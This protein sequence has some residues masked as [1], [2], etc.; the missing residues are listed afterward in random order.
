MN[1]IE[2]FTLSKLSSESISSQALCNFRVH[3]PYKVSELLN[4]ILLPDLHHDAWSASHLLDHAH[5]LRENSSIHLEELL[6]GRLIKREHLH[7]GDFEAGLKDC[8][9]NLPGQPFLDD[10]RL[11]DAAGAVV[12]SGSWR[13]VFGEEERGLPLEVGLGR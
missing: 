4:R 2:L 9:D 7:G 10:V 8:V 12:E 5:E 3:W 6:G 11:D 13:E 1:S